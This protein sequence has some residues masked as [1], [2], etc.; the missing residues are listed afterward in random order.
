MGADHTTSNL[1]TISLSVAGTAPLE[2]VELFRGLERIYSHPIG[3]GTS[4]N[5]VRVLWEGA[6]RKTSYSGVTWD[7]Q[8]Q[9]VGATIASVERL[10]FD[11]PRS[12]VLD[13]TA[14][15]L[16]WYSVTCGYRSGVVLDLGDAAD[17]AE[18]RLVVNTSLIS[19]P[20]FGGHGDDDPGRMSYAPAE[21]VI[22]S[23][24][25]RELAAGQKEIHLTTPALQKH[26]DSGDNGPGTAVRPVESQDRGVVSPGARR[27]GDGRAHLHRPGAT[28]GDQ[29]LLG[30]DRADRYGDGLDQPRL[31][32]LRGG[33]AA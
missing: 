28:A 19:R 3:A 29:S 17:D 15:A 33:A 24:S 9:V 7:G 6:S 16:C 20:Y 5:R 23:C 21:N 30:A 11:S 22:F 14:T 8:L 13:R 31:R 32:G 2:R 27:P 10:R 26:P 25:L 1:P 4:S 12:R 18:L